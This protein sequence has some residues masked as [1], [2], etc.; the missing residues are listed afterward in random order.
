[1]EKKFS[2][3]ECI[4]S[5]KLLKLIYVAKKK[6]IINFSKR[7]QK[8]KKSAGSFFVCVLYLLFFFF[9]FQNKILFVPLKTNAEIFQTKKSKFDKSVC[10]S[11]L[12]IVFLKTKRNM[13]KLQQHHLTQRRQRQ[14]QNNQNDDEEQ[15]LENTS[16]N[17]IDHGIIKAFF[18]SS[19]DAKTPLVIQT[20]EDFFQQLCDKKHF[21]LPGRNKDYYEHDFPVQWSTE[22]MRNAIK[23]KTLRHK[24]D[25]NIVRYNKTEKRRI[26]FIETMNLTDK[27]EYPPIVTVEHFDK[28]I[29]SG[30]SVRFLRPQEHSNALCDTMFK[31]EEELQCSCGINSY[32][33]PANGQGF[34]P[35][36]DDVDVFLLQLEGQ[37]HWRIYQPPTEGDWLS[38]VSSEDY[39]PD[40]IGKPV[41]D[42]VLKQ[43]EMLYMPRGTVHQGDTTH[44]ENTLENG[45]K[46][47]HSLH[48]TFSAFQMHTWADLLKET[49]NYRVEFAAANSVSFRHSL[50]LGWRT[51]MGSLANPTMMGPH[52][53]H[54]TAAQKQL[55]AE[56]QKKMRGFFGE[57]NTALMTKDG[58]LDKGV[59]EMAKKVLERR[60]PIPSTVV[61][62]QEDDTVVVVSQ[63]TKIRLT[64]KESVRFV[65]MS[66]EVRVYHCGGN[67]TICMG[68]REHREN[69]V[70]ADWGNNNNSNNNNS[71]NL[72]SSAAGYLRLDESF[73]PAV[74]KIVSKSPNWVELDSL[75]ELCFDEKKETENGISVE[76]SRQMIDA[77]MTTC[78]FELQ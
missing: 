18:L 30:W 15:N 38:R 72:P 65:M 35:H 48:V 37:K 11:T 42:I 9:F 27:D 14:Q 63:P 25:L 74:A 34:A 10:F 50:P 2:K 20:P 12:K 39:K 73:G 68:P 29:S 13:K 59:D 54:L 3:L 22:R 60:Q 49:F 43:G 6:K 70:K 78:C 62:Q 46:K 45:T 40:E 57:I 75:P 44:V 17:V 66:E 23:T 4:C 31:L 36:Y 56:L 32:W 26:D 28:A 53:I 71:S 58:S 21:Y 7:T 76:E 61:S 55:R 33:T 47:S 5:V 69:H 19:D 52:A 16:S 1:M 67:S 51:V 24:V 41:L 77:L 8:K 64:F